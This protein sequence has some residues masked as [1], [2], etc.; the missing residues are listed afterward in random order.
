[1]SFEC[2]RC[3]KCCL[4]ESFMGT[5]SATKEDIERWIIEDRWDILNYCDI[6]YHT[7]SEILGGDLWIDPS[8]REYLQC[9]FV[10]KIRDKDEYECLIN[11]TK[12]EVCKNYPTAHHNGICLRIEKKLNE[13][14]KIYD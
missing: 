9:P 11:E 1:M 12:P 4:D 8:G 7:N 5:L 14:M 10:R 3:G 2:R 13:R 6:Y